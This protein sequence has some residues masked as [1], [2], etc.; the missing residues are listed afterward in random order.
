MGCL[1]FFVFFLQ[2]ILLPLS[3]HRFV[4][5]N[6]SSSRSI[7]LFRAKSLLGFACAKWETKYLLWIGVYTVSLRLWRVLHFLLEEMLDWEICDTIL[8]R[9]ILLS[10]PETEGQCSFQEAV[11]FQKCAQC[12]FKTKLWTVTSLPYLFLSK[13]SYVFWWWLSLKMFKILWYIWNIVFS[14]LFAFQSVWTAE[15]NICIRM[16]KQQER[17]VKQT[18]LKIKTEANVIINE[19]CVAL[20]RGSPKWMESWCL[21]EGGMCSWCDC[22]HLSVFLHQSFWWGE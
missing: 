14:V 7:S 20:T 8:S 4:Q 12:V 22:E 16:R 17:R 2:N 18:R 21:E 11:D 5:G 6:A 9:A 13:I 15:L 19:D 3:S 10:F 1:L